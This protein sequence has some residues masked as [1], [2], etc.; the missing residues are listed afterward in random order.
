M[1]RGPT[2]LDEVRPSIPFFYFASAE[3]TAEMAGLFAAEIDDLLRTHGGGSRR[4]AVDKSA[5]A[6]GSR[7]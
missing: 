2:L 5:R 3:R 4:L 7:S 1:P 6:S